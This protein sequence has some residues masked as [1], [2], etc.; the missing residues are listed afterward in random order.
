MC[1]KKREWG[2]FSEQKE[3]DCAPGGADYHTT[4]NRGQF[5]FFF[6]LFSRGLASNTLVRYR[7]LLL[8]SFG[9]GISF[10]I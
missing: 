6:I 10:D 4:F 5:F 2:H 8:Q 3:E 9:S 1:L 7:H